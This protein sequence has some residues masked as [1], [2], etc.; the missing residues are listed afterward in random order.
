MGQTIIE[1]ILSHNTG[2][3]VKPGDIVTVNVDRVMLDD[4]M[5]PFIVDKF[6]EMG[7]AKVWDPDKVVLIYD[8]LVPASQQDDTRHFRVG[9]AFVEQYGIKNIH[10]SDGICHQ[11]MTEAGYVKPGM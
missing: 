3:A 7:F 11:L 2:K 8:H 6:H 1:K 10:R 9:D 5:I 4:I